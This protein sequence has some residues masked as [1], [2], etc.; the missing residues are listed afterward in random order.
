MAQLK[1]KERYCFGVR[2]Y[3]SR[4]RSIR[5]LK[6]QHAPLAFGY[7]VWTSCWLLM[8]YLKGS[9]FPPGLKI[10]DVGCGWGLAGIFCAKTLAASVTAVDADR[11]VFPY[12]LLH[13]E[14][15]QVHIT[16]LHKR[17]ENLT[18][19]DLTGVDVII[20]ADICFWDEMLP[21]IMAMIDHALAAGVGMILIADP[22]RSSFEDLNA[23]CQT[24]YGA[25]AFT[26]S[27]WRP[28]HFTG[29]I[30]KI[31]SRMAGQAGHPALPA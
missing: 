10:M 30:L 2:F 12:L 31:T 7:R 27:V 11:A 13:A 16:T 25:R 6:R 29:R 26:L 3:E 14:L 4:H 15:N 19:A 9:H 17:Y 1:P 8:D 22:G 18:S 28:Q 5:Q 24:R 20:G 21:Q 23:A